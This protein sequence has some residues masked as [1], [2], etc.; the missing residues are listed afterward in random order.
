MDEKCGFPAAYRS[1][2][3]FLNPLKLTFEENIRT[4][5]AAGPDA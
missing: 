1:D 3:T 5:H 4:S 2:A